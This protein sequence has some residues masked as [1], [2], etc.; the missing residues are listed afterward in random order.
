MSSNAQLVKLIE[1]KLNSEHSGG[2]IRGTGLVGG[3]K[4]KSGNGL[5]GGRKHKSGKGLV[6]GRKKKSGGLF[7]QKSKEN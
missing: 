5:V 4:R 3:R 7:P 2:Y 6:G 1:N